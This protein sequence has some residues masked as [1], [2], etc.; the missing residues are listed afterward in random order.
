M[1]LIMDVLNPDGKPFFTRSVLFVYKLVSACVAGIALQESKSRRKQHAPLV[2]TPQCRLFWSTESVPH[3]N[4]YCGYNLVI[5]LIIHV[6]KR[7][8]QRA[9]S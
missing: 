4:I 6:T 3:V 7:Q 8:Q 9:H 2:T 1:A 5:Y